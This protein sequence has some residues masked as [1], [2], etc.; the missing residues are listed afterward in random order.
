MGQ[1]LVYAG[2][3]WVT[4]LQAVASAVPLIFSDGLW[5]V[6]VALIQVGSFWSPA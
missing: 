1:L 6:G 2:L 4:L 5:A 3:G